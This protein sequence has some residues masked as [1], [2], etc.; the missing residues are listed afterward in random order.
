MVERFA[1]VDADTI[2]YQATITD[3]KVVYE[4]MDSGVG[5]QTTKGRASAIHH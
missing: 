1:F 2:Q 4:T 3:P 5:A